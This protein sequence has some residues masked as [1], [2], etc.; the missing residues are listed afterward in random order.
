VERDLRFCSLPEVV[1]DLTDI[2][3]ITAI[4]QAPTLM[5]L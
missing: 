3:V 1:V 5:V 4:P 2:E